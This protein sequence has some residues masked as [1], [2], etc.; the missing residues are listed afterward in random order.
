MKLPKSFHPVLSIVFPL[1]T[2][3]VCLLVTYQVF[4]TAKID[5][6]QK[7]QTYFDF[8]VREATKL[9][10]QRM[11]T[12]EQLLRATAAPFKASGKVERVEFKQYVESLDLANEFSGIQGVGF[13]LIVP[14]AKK[15]Q[16][17]ASIRSE[18]FPEYKIWPEGQR[19]IYTSIIYL[20]PF[21]NRNLRAFGYDMYSEAVRHA[22]MQKAI[23]SGHTSLSGKVKL[24]QESGKQEQ[25]GFLMY[26]P[27]YR[28]GTNN[29]TTADRREHIVGWVYAPFRMNDLMDGLF[30]EYAKDLDIHI[31]DGE[32]MTTE[33]LMYDSDGS[34]LPASEFSQ[35]IHLQISDHPWTIHIRPLHSMASRVDANHQNLVAVIGGIIS[36]LFSLLIWILVTGRDHAANAA[37]R[38]NIELII[39]RQRLNSIIEGTHVGTWEWNVQ[40]GEVSFNE[41]WANILGYKLSELEPISIETWI[42]FV[43]PDDGKL[44]G[45]FLEKHFS[46]ELAFYECEA[47][48][49]HKDGHW[50]WVLDRGKVTTWTEDGKPLMM[51]GTH[52]DITSRKQVE[53]Q[54]LL[55]STILE[56]IAEGVFLI[57]SSDSTIVFS[58]PQFDQMFGYQKDEIV[59]QH[60]SV[61]NAPSDK[62]PEE[63]TVTINEALRKD[64][65]WHGEV[66]SRRKDGT[67]FWTQA[68]VSTYNHLDFGQVWVAVQDDITERKLAENALRI[69]ATAFEA[70]EGMFVTDANSIILRVNQAFTKI[71]GFSAKDAI[72]QTPRIL[73]SGHHDKDFYVSLWESVHN[74][75][76]WSGD[77]WNKRKSGEIYPEQLTITAVKDVTGIVTNYVATLVDITMRKQT[78]FAVQQAKE[79]AE[80]ALTEQSRFLNMLTH[81]LKT[82][83]SVIRLSLDIVKPKRSIKQHIDQALED[84][85]GII[86][87]SA[88]M[89]LL[90]QRKL[91]VRLECCDID[92]ILR[93]IKANISMPDRLSIT[94]A[95]LPII[96]SD[97]QLIRIILNNLINN[98]IKYSVLKTKIEIDATQSEQQGKLGVLIRIQN[99]PGASGLPDSEKLFDKY[100]RSAGAYGMT[101]SGLGLYLVR[102]FTEL[103]GGS[104][105]YDVVQEKV[106]FTLWIPC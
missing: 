81:E 34:N 91:V 92:T 14:S 26:L 62:S 61:V 32:S 59:G 85:N 22:A 16:H 40:T 27:I 24:V 80:Q 83:L 25:A 73:N 20:E 29:D 17:I 102:S 36:V 15:T 74:A 7:T 52:Q 21:N 106:R 88:Q 57:R 54:L 65:V 67:S 35:T 72:G 105:D 69:A 46:G 71:T 64:G 75:G 53:S 50:L 78:E 76:G 13:S 44:S 58:N 39:E 19:D 43:H 55:H 79:V 28:N 103:L 84:M 33:A 8:R 18:G 90:E 9:I 37:E 42:K 45:E 3:T 30:G 87:R 56:N 99:Q 93:L 63:V 94:L 101:G 68:S 47:R 23:D 10:N 70:Q 60:V 96:H 95:P 6:K 49:Q 66:Y 1:L 48:M 86:E 31:F 5:V 41:H 97:L 4:N 12:Y 82:P 100:Y 89:D 98:A 51:A 11:R 2:L 38:M 77:I 104:V